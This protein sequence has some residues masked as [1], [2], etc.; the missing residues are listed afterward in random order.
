MRKSVYGLPLALALSVATAGLAAADSDATAVYR[1]WIQEMKGSERGPFSRIRW[2]CNDGT[3]LPPEPYACKEHD[4]GHQHGEWSGR[5]REL[6]EQGY[7]IATVLA[8][9]DP[10]QALA[11]PDLWEDYAQLLVERYLVSAD[12][13]WI[14]R[15]ARFYRGAIQEEDERAAA[16][17]LLTAMAAIPDWIGHRFT[18][19]RAGARMLPHGRDSASVVKVRQLAASLSD[20]DD[21]FRPLR[22]KIHGAPG[23]EDADKVRAY[24][25]GL[26]SDETR[27]PYLELAEEIDRVYRAAPLDQELDSLAARYTAAPWLQE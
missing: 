2:F 1:G 5:T 7:R 16:R 3:V 17:E 8:G 19:L 14:F 20:R 25:E 9:L 24:A 21:E 26:G 15:R 13:G 4:G 6:R 23:A 12:D 27:A 22:A 10:G 18:A 11:D